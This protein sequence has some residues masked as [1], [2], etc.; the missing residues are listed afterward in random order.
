MRIQHACHFIYGH[1][2]SIDDSKTHI[3]YEIIESLLYF[4]NDCDTALN[5]LKKLVVAE[6]HQNNEKQLTNEEL[7]FLIDDIDEK[8]MTRFR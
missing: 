7:Q 1:E 8:I 3:T 4:F 5:E 6:M 2:W